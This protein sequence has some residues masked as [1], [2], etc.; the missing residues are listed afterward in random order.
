MSGRVGDRNGQ[1]PSASFKH[2]LVPENLDMDATLPE[3]F[4]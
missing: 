1:V 2:S 3:R 4:H